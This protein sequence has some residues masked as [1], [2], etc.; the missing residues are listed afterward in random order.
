MADIPAELLKEPH[1]RPLRDQIILVRVHNERDPQTGGR[2]S[3]GGIDLPDI[4]DEEPAEGI[5]VSLG[6][7]TREPVDPRVAERMAMRVA[8]EIWG[9]VGVDGT[10]WSLQH[11]VIRDLISFMTEESG[12]PIPFNV[13]IGDKVLYPPWLCTTIIVNDVE[14]EMIAEQDIVGLV[15][16]DNTN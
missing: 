13:A 6:D 8:T 9:K 1:V 11:P 14:Y 12:K 3:A 7:G 10:D 4:A 5:V 16:D 15:V 2:K